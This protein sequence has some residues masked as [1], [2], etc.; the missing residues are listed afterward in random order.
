MSLSQLP[1]D[2]LDRIMAG[3]MREARA[4]AARLPLP[5]THAGQA[6]VLASPARFKVV[7]CGRRWRKS[8][9]SRNRLIRAAEAK[10]G[11][12]YWVW[13]SFTVGN[14]GWAMLREVCDGHWDVSE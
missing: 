5:G 13:P 1:P 14:T 2:K 7:N 9:T 12:Y 6:L 11:L 4:R 8:T 3:A 10:A